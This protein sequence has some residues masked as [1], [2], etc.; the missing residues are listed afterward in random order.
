MEEIKLNLGTT[1]AD[2]FN[3]FIIARKA[4]GLADKTLESYKSHFKAIARHLDISRNIE[5]LTKSEFIPSI[6]YVIAT[7]ILLIAGYKRKNSNSEK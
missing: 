4:K 2:T 6:F 5:D 3:D 1:I 7:L